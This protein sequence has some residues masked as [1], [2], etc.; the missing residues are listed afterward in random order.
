MIQQKKTQIKKMRTRI[1]VECKF[2]CSVHVSCKVAEGPSNSFQAGRPTIAWEGTACISYAP[3][4]LVDLFYI[5]SPGAGP[6]LLI[7][8]GG[9]MLHRASIRLRPRQRTGHAMHWFAVTLHSSCSTVL[10]SQ[11][12]LFLFFYLSFHSFECNTTSSRYIH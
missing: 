5:V 11:A 9:F 8:L 4:I 10:L 2:K 7:C 1:D 12:F 3:S 6:V